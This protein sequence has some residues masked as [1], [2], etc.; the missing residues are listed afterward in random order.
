M[1]AAARHLR[2]PRLRARAWVLLALLLAAAAFGAWLWVRDSS[3]VRVEQVTVSGA[4]GAEAPEVRQALDQAAREMTTLHV[5]TGRLRKAVAMYPQVKDLRAEADLLHRLNIEVIERPPV[6]A[7]SV[8]GKRTP[9][10]ADG[11]LLQGRLSPAGLPVVK[12]PALPAGGRVTGGQ[13]FRAL[14]AIAAAPA[15]LRRH[16]ARV[17][18]GRTGI[19]AVVER[20]PRI[21]L[22]DGSRPRAKWIAA[23]RVLGDRDAAGATYIDVRLPERP[24]AGGLPTSATADPAQASTSTGA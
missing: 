3:L 24:V 9:V 18:I 20:G 8:D 6:A 12:V 22:G 11:M 10:A 17:Q 23:A 16:I 4:T 2:P 7:L 21:L 14:D 1:V 15:A 13:T 5:D 19:E